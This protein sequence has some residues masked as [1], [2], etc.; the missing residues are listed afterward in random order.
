MK[1]QVSV[2]AQYNVASSGSLP[3]RIAG[4]Q[5][6]KMFEAFL[7]AMAPGSSDT[8]LDVGVTSDRSYSHSNYLE[9]WYPFK[10]RVTA[11]GIDDASFLEADYPGMR[12]VQADGRNLPF[13][14][15]SYDF[16]HSSA[17]LEHVGNRANQT[18]FISELWRVARRGIFITT[19]NRW[20]PVEF[21]TLSP[22]IHWLPP[23][24]FRAIM[25]R[26]GKAFFAQEENLNLLGSRDVKDIAMTVG[27]TAPQVANVTLGMWPTNLLLI[28]RKS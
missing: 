21:H 15:R 12:F 25:R 11:C 7:N 14:D 26:T 1:E 22:L 18:A 5:R 27:V 28:G 9:L 20:F 8:I 3:V 10:A 24:I 2:N 16:V 4:H 17:V 6:R 23:D 19:P 13:D